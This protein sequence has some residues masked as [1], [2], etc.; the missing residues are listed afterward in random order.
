MNR[1]KMLST[2]ALGMTGFAIGTAFTAP[3][4]P[5]GKNLSTYVNIVTGA[6]QELSPL[7]PGQTQLISKAIGI[8]KTF[9]DAYRAGK[10]VDAAALFENLA[11]V[12][13]QIAESAGLSSPSVKVAIAVA[14]IAMRAIAVLLKTQATDP[15]IAAAV[16][17]SAQRSP[18]A[19]RQKSLIEKLADE[20]E[21]N[22]LF[23]GAKP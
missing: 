21:I 7:L 4:C 17:D 9:D 14:G 10:F 6:L 19:M 22:A 20:S 12:V 23:Q 2:T 13:S 3:G 18:S 5:G 11:G 8:A 1:R 15:A 16:S